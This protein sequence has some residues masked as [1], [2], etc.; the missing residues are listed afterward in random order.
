MNQD[1]ALAWR[2]ASRSARAASRRSN[3]GSR[4]DAWRSRPAAS[5]VAAAPS[6]AS[7]WARRYCALWRASAGVMSG[8]QEAGRQ[9]G[10]ADGLGQRGAV[11]GGGRVAVAATGVI[12][13]GAGGSQVGADGL[14]CAG[15][16]AP[17]PDLRG[18]QARHHFGAGDGGSQRLLPGAE[19]RKSVVEGK[20]VD[21]G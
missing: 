9:I 1:P 4:S 13:G 16:Q 2:A 17:V 21:L 14:G 8:L 5:A 20:S 19:D 6:R 10:E 7:A 18:G 11:V 15:R 3:I 12:Q